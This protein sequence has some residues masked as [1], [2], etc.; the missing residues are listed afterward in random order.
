MKRVI[1]LAVTSLLLFATLGFIRWRAGEGQWQLFVVED[2][3][4]VFAYPQQLQKENQLPEAAKGITF[5]FQ[6]TQGTIKQPFLID[7]RKETGLRLATSLTKQ[8]LLPM[9]VG[10][11]EKGA[12]Q[13]FVDYHKDK[14]TSHEI[15]AKKATELVFEYTGPAGERIRQQLLIIAYDGNTAVYFVAQAK[16]ADFDM[17]NKKYFNR[18]FKSLK[19]E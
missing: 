8:E 5:L 2:P 18:M 3:K 1:L 16:A 15:S 13:R 9:L 7:V 6:A 10:N 17:L 19:F 12:P 14:E 4:L 11:F